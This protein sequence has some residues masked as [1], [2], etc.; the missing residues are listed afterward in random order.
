MKRTNRDLLVMLKQELMSPEAL[1]HEVELLHGLLFQ[2]ER[3][4]NLIIAHE[5][6]DLNRFKINNNKI[7]LNA[8]LRHQKELKGFTFLNCK[9]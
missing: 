1:E 9:N 8:I 2:V 5:I 6:I 4:D 7:L 3:I